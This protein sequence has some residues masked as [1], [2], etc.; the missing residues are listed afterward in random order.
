MNT[1]YALRLPGIDEL[2][3]VF[4]SARC[5]LEKTGGDEA[6]ACYLIANPDRIEASPVIAVDRDKML[7]VPLREAIEIERCDAA[8]AAFIE[9]GTITAAMIAGRMGRPRARELIASRVG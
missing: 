3:K 4:G 1:D 9:H 8:V 6:V 5:A 2:R 7:T